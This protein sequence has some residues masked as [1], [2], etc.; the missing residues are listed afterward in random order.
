MKTRELQA[1]KQRGRWPSDRIQFRQAQGGP[2]SFA[3]A[4]PPRRA[5]GAWA[6]RPT[7]RPS[8]EALGGVSFG[9]QE[10]GE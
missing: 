3:R 4:W 5:S 8:F 2:R 6:P 9:L 7:S 10:S 1:I